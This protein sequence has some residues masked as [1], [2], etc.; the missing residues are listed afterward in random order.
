MSQRSIADLYFDDPDISITGAEI[1][2]LDVPLQAEP[3]ESSQYQ[4]QGTLLSTVLSWLLANIPLASAT[5]N[6]VMSIAQ[7]NKFSNLK[8][9]AT[10]GAYSDLSGIPSLKT[11]ATSGAY[12]D[13]SGIPGVATEASSGLLTAADKVKIDNYPESPP[14]SLPPSGIAG[15][16]LAG[17]YPNPS[18]AAIISHGFSVAGPIAPES[19]SVEANILGPLAAASTA[20][21]TLSNHNTG[22]LQST[23]NVT[24]TFASPEYNGFCI[25][26]LTAPVTGSVPT[27]TL[28]S[29][30]VG[31]PQFPTALG[32]KTTTVFFYDGANY[33]V[34]SSTPSH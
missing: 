4:S 25:L 2:P 33:C 18:L 1:I 34:V 26:T 7:F 32:Q 23:V 15:G 19:I 16:D 29:S 6:G 5:A 24:F 27:V 17:S 21:F 3:T 28:P 12:S 8:T 11:V 9:V 30:V 31:T 22:T 20:N 13:L 10:T 14:T